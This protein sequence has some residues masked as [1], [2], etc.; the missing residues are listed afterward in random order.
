MNTRIWGLFFAGMLATQA[1]ASPDELDPLPWDPVESFNSQLPPEELFRRTHVVLSHFGVPIEPDSRPFLAKYSAHQSRSGLESILGTVDPLNQ[2]SR[3]S[4]FDSMNLRVFQDRDARNVGD[5][6]VLL[7]TTDIVEDITPGGFAERLRR[8]ATDN[9]AYL[10][11]KGLRIALD[12]G[13]MGSALWDQRTGKYVHS[14]DGRVLSEGILNLQTAL[15]LET[16]LQKLGAEVYVTHRTPGAVSTVPYES[17]SIQKYGRRAL[18]QRSLESWFQ[19]L[20]GKSISDVAL[21]KSFE[22]DPT[23]KSIF[24]ENSRSDYF[25]RTVDLF[26]RSDNMEQFNPDIS[27]VIHYDAAGTADDPN[28]VSPYPRTRTKVYV[29][30]SVDGSEWASRSDRLDAAKHLLD[31]VAWD[32]SLE[33]SRA[34]VHNLHSKLKID[35]DDRNA[36]GGFSRWLE[37][38]IFSRNLV[39]SRKLSGRA[40]TYVE[41]LHY[42]DKKE[43]EALSR[44]DY[45][46]QIGGT[47]YP[48]SKRL[49]QV[50]EALRDGVLEFVDGNR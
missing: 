10:P 18:L 20:L 4:I 9:S 14:R 29:Y 38:G 34:V 21:V 44:A 1:Y 7:N 3:F 32:K 19:K 33:L 12:P 45:S 5:Y 35:Y 23:V 15:L 41:C 11:L 2:F 48:Y 47:S 22:R 25:I 13:H 27:L 42:N 36:G 43:F 31:P 37:P 17:F 49:F 26:A 6:E 28:G 40:V 24:S 39:L 8:A 50:V 30:G 16:E 46:M